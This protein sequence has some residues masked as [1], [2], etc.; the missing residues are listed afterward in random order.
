MAR[1]LIAA[2]ALF[3]ATP[4]VAAEPA[5]L[6]LDDA[7][8]MAARKNYDLA[9]AK[10]Q[11]ESAGVDTYASWANVLPRIDLSAS[12]G[13]SYLGAQQKVNTYPVLNFNP[14]APEATRY[15]LSFEQTTKDIPGTGIAN[16]GLGVQLVQPIFDGLRGPRLIERARLSE[17]AVARQIDET[18]LS[19]SFDVTRR[20]YE[21]VKADKSA[22]V[23]EETVK[24]SEEFV[25]RADAL[26]NAGRL[27]KSDVIAARVN[28]GNDRI[29]LE[30]QRARAEQARTDLAMALGARPQEI[31]ALAAPPDVDR[32]E[33]ARQEPPG[34]D[35]L[36]SRAQEKRPAFARAKVLLEQAALDKRIAAADWW[37][38]VNGSLAYERQGPTFAG[39]DGVWGNPVRQ[40]VFTG[41]VSVSWNAFN[42][43]QTLAGEQRANIAERIALTQAAQL[44][45]QVEG[46]LARA[47]TNVVLLARAVALSA[48]NLKIAEEGVSLAQQRL[49]AGAAT[50][51]EVRDAALKLTQAKLTL[52]NARID[53]IVAR[54]DLN[55]AAGGAP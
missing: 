19:L 46:E 2:L 23:L 43:R 13:G 31:G 42:G 26:F 33:I 41:A 34:A 35:A 15:S 10:L 7:L 48:E 45:V 32:D 16:F 20:F 1:T 47:R 39:E 4:A 37:P 30:T 17:Q 3:A 25:Q 8:A 21:V 24:R 36:L 14:G 54:A 44:A 9:L 22:S 6:T 12:F 27:P 28:L 11:G 5:P 50:Q 52:V 49:D 29:S 18:A 40:F 53:A 38:Q 55:R 51:L